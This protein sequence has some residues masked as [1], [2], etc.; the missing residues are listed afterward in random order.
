VEIEIEA[1]VERQGYAAGVRAGL[2]AVSPLLLAVAPFAV[3]LSVGAH[4]AGFD[5]LETTM[6]SA[7]VFAGAAQIAIISLVASGAGLMAIVLTTLLINLR[8]IIYG[9]SLDRHLPGDVQPSRAILAFL[10]IDESYGLTMSRQARGARTDAFF[11]G[12]SAGL[13]VAFVLFTALGA[14]F[15]TIVP[16]IDRIG[17]EFIF[18]LAFIAL[19][20][21]ALR[22]MRH[23]VVAIV[24][25]GIALLLLRI[26]DPG[27]AILLAI[28]VGAAAGTV[29]R[30][31]T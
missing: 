18:P 19:L 12:A 27:V 4:S 13:Y 29:W 5:P 31:S 24:S 7:F 10:L 20:V 9:L 8:H 22:S 2:L 21:P 15:A 25:G 23:V 30:K 3:A 6:M 17:L 28:I 26:I 11:L 1:G 14:F 16:E